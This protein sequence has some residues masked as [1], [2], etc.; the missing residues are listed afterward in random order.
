MSADDWIESLILSQSGEH[1]LTWGL[2]SIPFILLPIRLYLRYTRHRRL[3]SDD[4]LLL[5]AFLLMLTLGILH[6]YQYP[7]L[8][9]AHS[10]FLTNQPFPPEFLTH[11]IPSLLKSQFA[12]T[13]LVWTLQWVC[14]LSILMFLRRVLR[15]WPGYMKWWWVVVVVCT[16]A[17]V[18]VML[19]NCFTCFPP[20]RKWEG[21]SC[22]TPRDITANNNG[23][24]AATI[25]DITSDLLIL[26]LPHRLLLTLKKIQLRNKLIISAIFSLSIF[27][28]FLAVFRIILLYKSRETRSI[29]L[30]GIVAAQFGQ[31]FGTMAVVVAILPALRLAFTKKEGVG[32]GDDVEGVEGRKGKGKGAGE[33]GDTT[34]FSTT[35]APE[36]GGNTPSL[37]PQGNKVT[38]N[39]QVTINHNNNQIPTGESNHNHIAPFPEPDMYISET[40]GGH[41]ARN[42]P[43]NPLMSVPPLQ[44]KLHQVI[45]DIGGETSPVI[46]KR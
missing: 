30:N 39:S 18:A 31:V 3:L 11:E 13:F 42:S 41:S 19:I 22:N 9:R 23:L 16:V 36:E 46:R 4:Y 26:L 33:S 17:W 12:K 44:V 10:Y 45:P 6:T 21:N 27:L 1:A 43:Q 2:M 29:W 8:F 34:L 14:K 25:L 38:S 28:I 32:F 20:R 5:P 24:I 15:V 37:S 40:N 7:I 35:W